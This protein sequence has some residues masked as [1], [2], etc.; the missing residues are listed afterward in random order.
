M[1]DDGGPAFPQLDKE[2]IGTLHALAQGMSLR[3]WLAGMALQGLGFI[4]EEESKKADAD[5][6]AACR[7][8]ATIAWKQADALLKIRTLE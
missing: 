2:P 7:R 8:V 1:N 4:H 5:E 3:D 6:D